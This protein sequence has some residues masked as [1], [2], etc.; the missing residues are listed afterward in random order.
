MK[1]KT[2]FLIIRFSSIGDIVLTTPVIR[3]LKEQFKGDVDIH[4]LTKL[5]FYPLLEHN[6]HI[7]KI[8]GIV[9]SPN[10][11]RHELT[12]ENFDYV[13]DLHKNLRTQKV[14][15]ML[16][17]PH[18][19]FDKLNWEKWLMVNFKVN[20][21]PEIHIVDRYLNTLKKWNIVND[22]KGLDY[23]LGENDRVDNLPAEFAGGYIGISVGAAH[24][25]KTLPKEKMRELVEK[26][27]CPVIL[28][29]GNEDI[30][31]ANFISNGISSPLINACGKYPINQSAFLIKNSSAIISHD[32]GIMHIASAFNKAL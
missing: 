30:E 22:N 26:L 20:K 6:P 15:H 5:S 3:C 10:E 19:S 21:L 2:K 31:K 12:Q 29:G 27:N 28:L 32:T 1:K 24:V 9:D 14:K 8:H 7:D 17:V 16:K 13:I 23:F 4:Y 11:I 25:T 18:Y